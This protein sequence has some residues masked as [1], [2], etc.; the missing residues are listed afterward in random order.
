M[1]R[2][3][4]L[5]IRSLWRRRSCRG[6]VRGGDQHVAAA[7]LSLARDEGRG[8]GDGGVLPGV[9][10]LGAI[11]RG[12]LVRTGRS[13]LPSRLPKVLVLRV[14]ESFRVGFVPGEKGREPGGEMCCQ[15]SP[16]QHPRVVLALRPGERDRG[17]RAGTEQIPRPNPATFPACPTRLNPP[18]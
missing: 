18:R 6:D 5:R 11:P 15:T 12:K 7:L 10:R 16:K 9:R 13:P 14:V 8:D 2:W 1:Q 4:W 3:R 17:R